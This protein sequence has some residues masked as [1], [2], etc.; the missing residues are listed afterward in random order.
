MY[1]EQARKSMHAYNIH[2]HTPNPKILVPI[3]SSPTLITTQQD[4][5][6]IVILYFP[7]MAWVMWLT[8]MLIQ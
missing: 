8:S 6:S 3:Q 5:K 7:G 2:T 1:K 4:M